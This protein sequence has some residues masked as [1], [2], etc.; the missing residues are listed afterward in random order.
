[1]T[2]GSTPDAQN[3]TTT[4]S[5]SNVHTSNPSTSDTPH[6]STG[7]SVLEAALRD[8]LEN[9][10]DN[11]HDSG[12]IASARSEIYKLL[13]E[14]DRLGYIPIF[15]EMLYKVVPATARTRRAAKDAK[16]KR[17]TVT[18]APTKDIPGQGVTGD[19]G[20]VDDGFE[21]VNIESDGHDSR[22]EAA[23]EPPR[24]PVPSTKRQRSPSSPGGD[25]SDSS[26][27]SESSD[28]SDQGR[29][30]EKES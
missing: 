29:K 11:A 17:S 30:K 24:L 6:P 10:V 4:T 7:G 22:A 13:E 27:D 16:G 12:D 23:E 28:S 8:R 15:D 1:M 20:G 19:E 25:S 18:F 26:S 2:G 3:S 21:G 14:S 5:G 9:I